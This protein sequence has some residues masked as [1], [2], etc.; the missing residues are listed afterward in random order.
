MAYDG[1]AIANYVLDYCE[2]LGR[3]VTNLALQKIVYF[4][5]AWTLARTGLP[6][7]AHQFEAWEHGPVLPFLY[8]EF[9]KAGSSAISFRAQQLDLRTGASVIASGSL[10]PDVADLLNDVINFYSRRTPSELRRLSH[11]A[12]GPWDSVWNHASTVN[13]GMRIPDDEIKKYFSSRL[14]KLVT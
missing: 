3:P 13:P 2:G 12:G 10:T 7:L 11:T 8:R 1:R 6:L 14:S 4:C 5:H 9:S